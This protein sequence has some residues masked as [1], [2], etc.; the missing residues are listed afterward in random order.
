[1]ASPFLLKRRA[2][3]YVRVR[4]PADIAYAF[5]ATHLTRS[6]STKDHPTARRRAVLATAAFHG[7]WLEARAMAVDRAKVEAL[8]EFAALPE[9]EQLRRL[10]RM[11][12]SDEDRRILKAR[13]DSIVQATEAE[14]AHANGTLELVEDLGAALENAERKGIIRGMEKA[15]ERMPVAAAI[16]PAPLQPAPPPVNP[17]H[18]KMWHAEV[19]PVFLEA[20]GFGESTRES[21]ERAFRE[22]CDL[23]GDKPIVDLTPDDIRRYRDWLVAKPGK[24]PGS[25][26]AH[27]SIVKD[28]GHIKSFLTW[29]VEEDYLTASPGERVKAP[30]AKSPA[31]KRDAGIKDEDRRAFTVPELKRIFDSP[32]YTG[33][34]SRWFH[35]D[36]GPNI[37]REDRYYFLLGMLLT[38]ARTEELADAPAE[39]Y[40]L[41][42]IPCLNLLNV[43]VKT[44]ASPRIIPIQPTLKK[45]GFLAFAAAKLK[46]GLR[47]FEGEHAVSDWSK[48]TNRYIDDVGVDDPSVVAYSLRHNF[49][50][51]LR[52]ANLHIETT[53]RIFGH[54]GKGVGPDYGPTLTAPEAQNFLSAIKPS[55]A[56]DHLFI[57]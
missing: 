22:C 9:I 21:H 1:M 17:R 41:D 37:Y 53:D 16:A 19:V 4:I 54:A 8:Q 3:W 36:P 2:G 48:W 27:Q 39:M 52:A 15:L 45:A 35:R 32:L 14:L 20:K 43:A 18:Q 33:C 7:V 29:A 47:L 40:D 46:A 12:L 25:S 5:G 49:R 10:A 26:Y 6:L 51:A 31:A 57:C 34:Q 24:T 50:Q 44:D 11:N 28:L 30:E 23:L 56:L 55:I 42:G 13:I 38:G